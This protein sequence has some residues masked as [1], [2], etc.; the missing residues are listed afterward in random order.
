MVATGNGFLRL[1]I[2]IRTVEKDP[3]SKQDYLPTGSILV[4]SQ[5]WIPGISRLLMV[6]WH[7]WAGDALPAFEPS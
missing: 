7:A 5:H 6:G 2:A 1:P 3:A 4:W